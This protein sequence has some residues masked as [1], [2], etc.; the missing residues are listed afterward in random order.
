MIGISRE[1]FDDQN[2]IGN[3][4]NALLARTPANFSLAALLINHQ[5]VNGFFAADASGAI[6]AVVT[7]K[8]LFSL[9]KERDAD[10]MI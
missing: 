4:F 6:H 8:L 5:T 9:A 2:Q 7:G 1:L 10:C 3:R